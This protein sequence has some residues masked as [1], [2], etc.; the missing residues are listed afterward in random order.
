VKIVS[1]YD[2]EAVVMF[3]LN[4][5]VMRQFRSV[6]KFPQATKSKLFVARRVAN[7]FSALLRNK[8]VLL[9]H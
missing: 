6:D 4:R 2:S 1:I 9:L 5:M 8:L 7:S 3:V